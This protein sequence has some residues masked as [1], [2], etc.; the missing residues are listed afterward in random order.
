MALLTAGAQRS[1]SRH[2]AGLQAI[3]EYGVPRGK[4]KPSPAILP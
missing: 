4:Y 1:L 3:Y 2:H